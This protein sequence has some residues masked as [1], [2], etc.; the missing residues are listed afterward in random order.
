VDGK[1]RRL[2]VRGGKGAKDRYT[3][4]ADAALEVLRAYWRVYEPRDWLFP[5]ARPDH[6][7]SPRTTMVRP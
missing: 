2:L 6:P 3:I 7:I 4:I 5:S 1:Q